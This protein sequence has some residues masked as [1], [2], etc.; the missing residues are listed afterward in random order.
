MKKVFL[1]IL[2]NS[3]ENTCSRVSFL[4][5]LQTEAWNLKLQAEALNFIKKEALA[6]VSSYE[7]FEICKNTFSY[8]TPPVAVS[9]ISKLP[10]KLQ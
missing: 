6:R 9:G 7:F 10:G 5:K 4:I 1:K 8:R 2:Q 3:Q